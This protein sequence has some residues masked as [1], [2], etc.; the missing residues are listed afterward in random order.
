MHLT[1]WPTR[2]SQIWMVLSQPPDSRTWGSLGTQA[3]AYTELVCPVPML[4]T[5]WVAMPPSPPDFSMQAT[6]DF[7]SSY[8]R[9]CL[10]APALAKS[11]LS[12]HVASAYTLLPRSWMTAMTC[13]E[14]E[15]NLRTSSPLATSSWFIVSVF[16]QLSG[17]HRRA[18]QHGDTAFGNS[19]PR[20]CTTP[21]PGVAETN[22]TRPSWHP[23]ATI[24]P[25]GLIRQHI[26]S[27]RASGSKLCSTIPSS[28]GPGPCILRWSG[29]GATS[30]SSSLTCCRVAI[31]FLSFSDS[32]D[33]MKS[34]SSL[35]RG[36]SSLSCFMVLSLTPAIVSCG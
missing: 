26:A 8:T 23:T 1:A 33:V 28:T 9:T 17:R 24:F 36:A 3:T 21:A 14:L 10:S 19:S 22:R 25:S 35:A 27:C 6:F 29:R 15:W 20:V 4:S 30:T 11:G 16:F 32:A 12:T 31:D 5:L 34:S 2:E 18:V 13:P 7:P